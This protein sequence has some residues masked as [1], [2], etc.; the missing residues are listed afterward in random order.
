MQNLIHSIQCYSYKSHLFTVNSQI[1]KRCKRQLTDCKC[2]TQNYNQHRMSHQST[3]FNQSKRIRLMSL[4]I[5]YTCIFYLLLIRKV[6]STMCKFFLSVHIAQLFEQATQVCNVDD[7]YQPVVH[8][9][10]SVLRLFNQ[11]VDEQR[12]LPFFN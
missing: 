1:Y 3:N 6:N 8:V 10:Q 4:R 2:C 5:H 12:Q 11:A 7:Q 9:R